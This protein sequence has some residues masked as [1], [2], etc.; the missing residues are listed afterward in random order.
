MGDPVLFLALQPRDLAR[1]GDLHQHFLVAL[2]TIKNHADLAEVER[3]ADQ[4]KTLFLDSGVYS[5]CMKMAQ[6]QGIRSLDAFAKQPEEIPGFEDLFE[7]Y[8]EVMGKLDKKIWGYIEIDVGGREAKKRTRARLE[9]E[10]LHPIPVYH[11]LIDGPEYFHELASKYPRIC[12]SNLAQSDNTTRL[13]L[14]SWVSENRQKY[15]GLWIHTLG[16]YPNEWLAA[17][18]A[19][20]SDTSGWIDHAKFGEYPEVAYLEAFSDIPENYRYKT[21]DGQEALSSH[22]LG[23]YGC[24]F[25]NLIWQ[26]LQRELEAA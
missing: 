14:M 21:G 9:A 7:W 11:P 22:R 1:I 26:E 12:V 16:L 5:L 4:G 24:H 18:P 17:Y 25:H 2:N 13:R 20:S 6:D 3:W 10:G 8:V 15:P 19:E 23:T